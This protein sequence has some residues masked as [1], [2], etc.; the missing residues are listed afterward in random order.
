MG[1]GRELSQLIGAVSAR[2]GAVVTGPAGVGKTTFALRGVEWAELHGMAHRRVSATRAAREL[3]F[4]A[5][6][7]LLPPEPRDEQTPLEDLGALLGHYCR[8]I[9]EAA[10][11]RP[12]LVFVDDA[13]LLDKGSAILM[14]QL[15]LTAGATV[16]AT[17]RA[18]EVLPDPV[19]ALWK[20][21]PA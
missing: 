19:I 9:V 18:G 11:G 15:A 7:S 17:V 21:G 2:R 13:H 5:F 14:H 8:A 6:A 12:L 1:R 10:L 20:D 3:P 4:G 16:L